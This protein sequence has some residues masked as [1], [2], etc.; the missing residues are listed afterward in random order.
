MIEKIYKPLLFL[1]ALF[2]GTA[3][4]GQQI[5]AGQLR[6]LKQQLTETRS[7]TAQV[8]ILLAISHAYNILP[9]D[10]DH[11]KDTALRYARQAEQMSNKNA[12]QKGMGLSYQEIAR[13]FARH[14]DAKQ[15]KAYIDRAVALFAK[16]NMPRE[17][18][19]AWLLEEE[20]YV[21]TGGQDM[22]V[23]IDYYRK[24]RPLFNRAGATERE[25]ATLKILGDFL[26]VQDKYDEALATLKESLKL[27]QKTKVRELQGLYDLIAYVSAHMGDY[28]SGV[29]YGLDALKTAEAVH[30][31]SLQLCTIYNRIGLTYTRLMQFQQSVF[32][33]EKAV[34]VALKF[35]DTSTTVQVIL[36]Y[37][38]ALR[39]THQT[40]KALSILKDCMLRYTTIDKDTWILALTSEVTIYLD[41]NK[42]K[43]AG[44]VCNKMFAALVT[45]LFIDKNTEAAVRLS[46]VKYFIA[47]AQYEQARKS[48]QLYTQINDRLHIGVGAYASARY[49]YIIDSLQGQFPR[50]LKDYQLY[51]RF[52]DSVFNIKKSKQ[53]EE[54]R[55]QYQT[56]KKEEDIQSLEKNRKLEHEKTLQ[57]NNIRNLTLIGSALLIVLLVFAFVNYRAKQ[58][59]NV[60]LNKLIVEKDDLLKEREWLIKEIHHRVKNNLQ[61]VMGLLQRQS[62]YIDNEAALQ[63]IQNSESR[64]HSIALIHQKLYQSEN[65]DTINMPEY[66]NDLVNCIKDSAD[67]GSR[68]LFEKDIADI[69]LDVSQAVPLGLILNEAITNAVKYAYPGSEF[70]TI[71]VMLKC[72]GG[73]E[74]M[75]IIEDEG[76]GLKPDFDLE[77]V[78][79]LGL[80]LM[81][82]LSK[83]I[84]GSFEMKHQQG[85]SIRIAFRV[86][87]FTSRT[88]DNINT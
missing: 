14:H 60:A 80:N 34:S 42:V 54:L 87:R 17:E 55:I 77:K 18:A 32:Y 46:A 56:D 37:T 47:S 26:Q 62:A 71:R 31:T 5:S 9:D 21:A 81:K 59:T 64:M 36:N 41:M 29:R 84:N 12:Y 30:D 68:I 25:A 63:A 24:A 78:N 88:R 22:Q 61:I 49:L 76:R 75:L 44:A 82:G 67:T 20:F 39:R 13:Y 19:E 74:V 53:I 23:R 72:L 86:E 65:L 70:G 11:F 8:R 35:K 58:R 50:A 4:F 33:A 6:Q 10:H 73:D 48:L 40:K 45:P 57:A 51:T 38:D 69:D 52:K 43:E 28:E 85:V 16:L 83:Q 2:W 66:I 79:S 15:S 27:Y 7:D 1:L 3:A